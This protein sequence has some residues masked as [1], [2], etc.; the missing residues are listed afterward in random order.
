MFLR[1]D[2]FEEIF[3]DKS[4]YLLADIGRG[5]TVMVICPALGQFFP[6][7]F[8]STFLFPVHG[9]SKLYIL[10]LVGKKHD[11]LSV[12]L[13]RGM[14]FLFWHA[15]APTLCRNYVSQKR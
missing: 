4:L 15:R 2:D 11:L 1:N 12:F 13:H 3:F 8:H 9:G 14:N 7:F 10:F 6:H 5:I